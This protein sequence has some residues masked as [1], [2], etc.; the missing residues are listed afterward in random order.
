MRNLVVGLVLG[1]LLGAISST[2]VAQRA[3]GSHPDAVTA[4]PKH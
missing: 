2:L 1:I 4:E 3:A